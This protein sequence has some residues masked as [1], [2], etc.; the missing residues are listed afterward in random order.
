MVRNGF[1]PETHGL[2]KASVFV[3]RNTALYIFLLGDYGILSRGKCVPAGTDCFPTWVG[4]VR[5]YASD[6]T[7]HACMCS[8][9]IILHLPL[10]KGMKTLR[11][12]SSAFREGTFVS[13]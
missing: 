11:W 6:V 2:V 9:I 4:T 13:I 1:L 3:F 8:G 12:Q 10:V 7:I 5:S